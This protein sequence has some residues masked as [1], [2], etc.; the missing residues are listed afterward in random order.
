M[1]IAAIDV[2]SNSIHL[3]VVETDAMGNQQVLAREKHMVRLARGVL[4]TG[5]I[6]AEAFQAGL[7][8]L[9]LMAEVIRGLRCETVMACGTAALREAAN[10]PRFIEEA[11]KLGI[12]IK[13]IS[14][15]EEASLI[16]LAVSRAIPFPDEPAVLLD[17][18]GGSTELTWLVAGRP[19][20]TLSLPWGLQRL[21]DAVP[22]SNPPLP[23]EL[24][25]LRKFI[26][27]VL[28][29]AG[30]ALPG[31]L[32][33]AQVVLGTSGTLLDLAKG[34]SDQASFDLA[35]LLR[36]KRRLWKATAQDRVELLGVDPKRAEVLHVGATWTTGLMEWLGAGQ[37]RCLPVG[38][39]EGMVWKALARGGMALPVLADRRKASVA[40][41]GAKLDPDPGHSSHVEVLADQ[42]F[43]DLMPFFE[44]G[45]PERELL[46][47][48]ARLHDVGLSLSEKSHHKHG[49]YLIQN[50]NL[51]GFWPAE[52]ETI[53]QIV[54]FH[55]GKAP[56][57]ASH[58]TFALLKPWTQHVVEKLSAIIRV[59]DAL[60]RT[61]RQ[62]VRTVRLL[63]EGEDL[64]LVVTGTG[65]LRP[66]LESLQDKGRLLYRLLDRNVK[67]VRA[68]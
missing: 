16:Y 44:L 42:L 63:P 48:A 17:I 62:A 14:G 38:L 30:Q 19:S 12:H 8:A 57:A 59:A 22:T 35:Q 40:A 49:A 56:S 32:P 9:A 36:F 29:K 64:C 52:I 13:V 46:G 4:R 27:K 53:A 24:V 51:A 20:A 41:L 6:G 39:R 31:D 61:R 37:V 33:E 15:E 26:R 2:G 68:S 58:E 25:R 18:G 7:E 47:Y 11:D 5:E 3:V 34:A 43:H 1:R 10:A 66:E 23:E 67:V 54:R 45:D 60:D 65:D 28:K 21:A 55:R 50:A